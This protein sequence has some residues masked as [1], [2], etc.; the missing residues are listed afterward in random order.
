MSSALKVKHWTLESVS[1]ISEIIFFIAI[2]AVTK[3]TAQGRFFINASLTVVGGNLS[4]G[5]HNISYYLYGSLRYQVSIITW[6]S[7]YHWYLIQPYHLCN[8]AGCTFQM[9]TKLEGVCT[10][11]AVKAQWWMGK[12]TNNNSLFISNSLN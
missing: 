6:A 7:A 5:F 1:I 8:L 3:S 12:R 2:G 11:L 10:A 9:E 4:D